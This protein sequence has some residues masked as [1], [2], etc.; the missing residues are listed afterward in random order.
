MQDHVFVSIRVQTSWAVSVAIY[1]MNDMRKSVSRAQKRIGLYWQ[2]ENIA[3]CGWHVTDASWCYT[4]HWIWQ[5]IA[6]QYLGSIS[7]KRASLLSWL[8][9]TDG[10]PIL[11]SCQVCLA[12][13]FM[14]TPTC[15]MFTLLMYPALLHWT[16]IFAP[17]NL[18]SL[19][20]LMPW[21]ATSLLICMACNLNAILMLHPIWLALS[22]S[23]VVSTIF[24]TVAFFKVSQ[25]L[26]W[27]PL[28]CF[29][30]HHLDRYQDVTVGTVLFRQYAA[31]VERRISG[32]A[33]NRELRA[34]GQAGF[35]HNHR[36]TTKKIQHVSNHARQWGHVA[37]QVAFMLCWLLK[38]IWHQ[39][40]GS[41][42]RTPV[43]PHKI[44]DALKSCYASAYV[45]IPSVSRSAHFTPI[46]GTLK[47]NTCPSS[48]N[49]GC[50][51]ELLRQCQKPHSL[52]IIWTVWA[53]RL[54]EQ[55]A[56]PSSMQNGMETW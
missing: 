2:G 14:P 11:T 45:D 26:T 20:L 31:V 9:W 46:Q 44:L 18:K 36:I 48:Q 13:I 52:W 56:L 55:K 16:P 39:F 34:A 1:C 53:S 12:L 23:T 8:L 24:Y 29:Q 22:V 25:S 37:R 3:V 5:S 54:V 30:E 10:W 51:E 4:C 32:W 40:K 43:Q 50:I 19:L 42:K 17:T 15:L 6:Q 47:D 41:T 28:H 27:R 49:T 7:R 35:R 33:A 38:G 21:N